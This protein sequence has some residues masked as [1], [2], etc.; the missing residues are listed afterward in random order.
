MRRPALV[1]DV[2]QLAGM[3]IESNYITGEVILVDGGLN[4]T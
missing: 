2:A 1:D 4:L 3:V